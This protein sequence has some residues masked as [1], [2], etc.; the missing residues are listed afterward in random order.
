MQLLSGRAGTPTQANLTLKPMIFLSSHCPQLMLGAGI[1]RHRILLAGSL[2]GKGG[3][4]AM[5]PDI[6]WEG[7]CHDQ[8]RG[9]GAQ[10]RNALKHVLLNG[11]G[12]VCC[13]SCCILY[14]VQSLECLHLQCG[15]DDCVREEETQ[16]PRT[17]GRL[18]KED[19]SDEFP[20]GWA[21]KDE[22]GACHVE[23]RAKASQAHAEE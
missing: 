9:C 8:L 12:S 3:G 18:I 13:V 1:Q 17:G 20:F 10:G 4:L 2:G 19:S 5:S 21:L 16:G 22:L 7:L 6:M 11:R 14:P 23:K 15:F